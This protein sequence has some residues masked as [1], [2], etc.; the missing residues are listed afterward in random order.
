MVGFSH[1]IKS[2]LEHFS[3]KHDIKTLVETGTFEGATTEIASSIFDEVFSIELDNKLYQEALIKFKD[4]K[5][6]FCIEGESPEMLRRLL[7]SDKF[8]SKNVIFY[9][10]AH[11]AGEKTSRSSSDTPLLSEIRV[12]ADI[13]RDFSDLIIIDDISFCD[14]VTK[15]NFAPGSQYFPNGGLF[16]CDWIGVSKEKILQ[17]LN[18]KNV[19]E[20]NDRLI[21]F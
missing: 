4:K 1:T 14:K 5:N 9:L 21:L 11:W 10:D 8:K 16:E 13:R 20:R 2:E 18:K 7:S 17:L 3:K 12:I 19:I 15:Y 6:I